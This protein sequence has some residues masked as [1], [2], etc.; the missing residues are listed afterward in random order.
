MSDQVPT[1]PEVFTR[2]LEQWRDGDDTALDKISPVIYA[3]LRRRAAKLMAGERAG[4]TLAPTELVHEAFLRLVDDRAR[5]YNNRVHFF[6][7]AAKMMRDLLIQHARARGARKRDAALTVRPAE[8]EALAQA[9]VLDV[10]T[11]LDEALQR[12]EQRDSRK[13]RI[14][15]L[16]YFAGLAVEE[17][18]QVLQLGTATVKRDLAFSRTWLRAFLER[19]A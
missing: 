3:E 16:Y 15:E 14:V 1:S 6:A 5:D 18:A 7:L 13:G 4:H 10:V 2:Y 11:D 8:L 9:P 12:L 19:S 17:I